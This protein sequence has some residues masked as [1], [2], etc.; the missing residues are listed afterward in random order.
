MK[1]GVSAPAPL[2]PPGKPVKKNNGCGTAIAG[3]IALAVLFSIFGGSNSKPDAPAKPD[4]PSKPPVLSDAAC[5]KDLS[6]IGE[7]HS[8]HAAVYCKDKIEAQASHDVKWSD[9]LLTPTMS[10]YRWGNKDHTAVTYIGDKVSFQNGFGAF[11]PM[12]YLCTVDVAS[13]AILNVQVVE[14][15]LPSD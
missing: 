6:C 13:D 4:E 3:I 14:G 10:R 5:A 11:T 8:T 15:R 1:A 7:K 12:T 9:G 2:P